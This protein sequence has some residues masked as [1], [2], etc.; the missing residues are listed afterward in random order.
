MIL[1]TW[2]LLQLESSVT[3]SRKQGFC[4]CQKKASIPVASRTRTNESISPGLIG[5]DVAQR[6]EGISP[7]SS[8]TFSPGSTHEP[9]LKVSGRLPPRWEPFSPGSYYKPGLK[10]TFSP[11][12]CYEP[13]LMV[14]TTFYLLLPARAILTSPFLVRFTLSQAQVHPIF[15]HHLSR[16]AA[17]ISLRVSNFILSSGVA[18]LAH[19]IIV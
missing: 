9:G 17:P 3:T 1:V 10:V 6:P 14:S 15:L 13:G 4:P 11:G 16:L 2:Q 7:G 18:D 19:F 8:G 12:L 5:Q